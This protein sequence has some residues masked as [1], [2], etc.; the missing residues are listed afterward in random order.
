MI[1]KQTQNYL[2]CKVYKSLHH[3]SKLLVETANKN[4]LIKSLKSK[5]WRNNISDLKFKQLI[6]IQYQTQL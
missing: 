6:F 2:F 5:G 3:L 4:S 1:E